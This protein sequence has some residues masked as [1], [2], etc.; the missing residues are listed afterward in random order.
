[1]RFILYLILGVIITLYSKNSTTNPIN[2]CHYL[3]IIVLVL[4]GCLST[5]PGIPNLFLVELR[6]GHSDS[7]QVR[8]GYYGTIPVRCSPVS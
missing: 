7:M 8:V 4:T 6:A 1:M 2:L 5:S 3:I